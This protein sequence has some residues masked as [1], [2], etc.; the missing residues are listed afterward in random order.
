MCIFFFL[1]DIRA[2]QLHYH[3][4]GR[5]VCPSSRIF[6]LTGSAPFEEMEFSSNQRVTFNHE[7]FGSGVP[8]SFEADGTN[9]QT[10]LTSGK[11]SCCVSWAVDMNDVPLA[12]PSNHP[13]GACTGQR[14]MQ[15]FLTSSIPHIHKKY[16]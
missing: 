2:C 13:V 11:L 12:P 1:L 7:G 5:G 4:A 8:F 14:A 9:M 3:P 10:L 15:G 16:K 6:R